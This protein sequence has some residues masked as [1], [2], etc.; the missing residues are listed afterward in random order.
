MQVNKPN[1][2]V[3]VEILQCRIAITFLKSAIKGR[4]KKV[5]T[6]NKLWIEAIVVI[7]AKLYKNIN[8]SIK[9]STPLVLNRAIRVDIKPTKKARP[10]PPPKNKLSGA[11]KSN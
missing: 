4:N 7:K 1:K 8:P 5:N 2:L 11:I 10:M 3:N 9:P 6:N